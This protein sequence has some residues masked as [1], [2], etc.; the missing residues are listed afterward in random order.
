LQL[1]LVHLGAVRR[2]D[3]AELDADVLT[4]TG[5]DIT[6]VFDRAAPDVLQE[7]ANR[8]G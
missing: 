1:L 7:W 2:V 3:H 6:M 8:G 5:P 4:L